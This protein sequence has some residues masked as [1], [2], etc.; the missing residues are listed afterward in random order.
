MVVVLFTVVVMVVVVMVMVMVV[1][2]AITIV[3]NIMLSIQPN[4]KDK[5]LTRVTCFVGLTM[6]LSWWVRNGW[7]Y[8][9]IFFR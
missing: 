7:G 3:T 1:V 2:M 4:S 9:L 8:I 6:L 5:C